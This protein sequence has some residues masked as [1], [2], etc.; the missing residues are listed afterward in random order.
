MNPNA[1]SSNGREGGASHLGLRSQRT[2]S[3]K[4]G[5][6]HLGDWVGGMGELVREVQWNSD[7]VRKILWLRASEKCLAGV[8]SVGLD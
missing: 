7:F 1:G 4:K 6:S 2:W 5:E 8:R 3:Q